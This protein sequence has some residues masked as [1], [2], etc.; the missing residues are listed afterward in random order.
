MFLYALHYCQIAVIML[1]L[2]S[3]Y[4]HT[5]GGWQTESLKYLKLNLVLA[6]VTHEL[7]VARV[8]K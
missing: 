6:I 3:E 5:V 2:S 4:T 8:N 7:R 1:P